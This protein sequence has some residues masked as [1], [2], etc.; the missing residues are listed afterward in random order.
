MV[1]LH[2]SHIY[3]ADRERRILII[4]KVGAGKSA[5]GNAILN[6]SG[7]F[8]SRQSFCHV[9]QEIKSGVYQ[10][11]GIQY[12][13][14]DT[15]GVKGLRENHDDAM[16]Q[17][18]RCVL[19]T[20]P[21]FHC[22]VWVISAAQRIET[23]DIEIIKEFEALLTKKA[24]EYTIIV[25]TNI[26]PSG[27]ERLLLECAEI[28]DLCKSCRKNYLSFD[29]GTDQNILRNQV[30]LFF[31]KLDQI[32]HFNHQK[33][34]THVMFNEASKL[35]KKDAKQ[36]FENKIRGLE[37]EAMLE[38]RTNALKGTSP[39]DEKLRNL[40]KQSKWFSCNIL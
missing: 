3:S 11:N 20:S 29:D 5:V 14:V 10:K 22:I 28:N 24:Y 39:N 18:T 27:L 16:K 19:A 30:E 2:L 21:G 32:Y 4:G 26:K 25:F 35:L 38:A 40:A 12:F 33:P 23:V 34:F 37:E 9:T 15:P 1:N 13:V 31:T 7:Y 36:I 17:L 6:K 8:E